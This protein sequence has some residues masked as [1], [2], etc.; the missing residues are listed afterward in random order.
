[1]RPTKVLDPV[2]LATLLLLS[3]LHWSELAQGQEA[4]T[5]P[6]APT[7]APA[8]VVPV[9]SI[10]PSAE[11]A[12]ISRDRLARAFAQRTRSMLQ[13]ELIFLGMLESGKTMLDMALELSPDNEHLWRLALDYSITMEDGSEDAAKLVNTALAKLGQLDPNDQI[14]RLRRVLASVERK[15]TAEARAAAYEKLLTPASIERLG[16]EVAARVAFDFAV[17]LRRVGDQEGFERELLRALDLDP[18]FPEATEVAAGYFRARAPDA[19]TEASVLRAALL[20]NPTRD[21]AALGLADLCLRSG[22]YRAAADILNVEAELL[23]TDFPDLDFDGILSDLCIACWGSDSVETALAVGRKRQESLNR[24]FR[25]QV[26]RQGSTLSV[27]DM[28]KLAY[29]MSMSLSST[30]AALV[31]SV[32]PDAAAGVLA[33]AAS[34]AETTLKAMEDGGADPEAI[35]R[36]ALEGAFIQLWLGGDIALAKRLIDRAVIFMPL[37]EAARARFDGWI[38]LRAGD[39]AKAK[40]MFSSVAESDVPAKLGLAVADEMLGDRKAAAREFLAIAKAQSATAIGLWSRDRLRTILGSPI[41]VVDI[42]TDVERAAALPKDFLDMMRTGKGQLLMRIQPRIADAAPWDPMIFDIEI[43]NRSAWPISITADGPLMD[44]ATVTAN[45]NIPGEPTVA[46]PFALVALNRQFAIAPGTSLFV[47][48]DISLTD[49][50][51]AMRDDALSGAFVS[52][53]PILN[54]RTTERGLEPGPL[55]IEAESALVHVRGEKVT[56]NWIDKVVADLRDTTRVPDPEKIA[57]LASVVTRD[58]K[59]K[60]LYPPEVRAALADM[61][62]LL[63]DAAKRLWPE[64]RAWLI[65]ASPKGG[66]RELSVRASDVAA[67]ASVDGAGDASSNAPGAEGEAERD[68]MRGFEQ[69]SAVPELEPLDLVLMSDEHPLVRTAWIAVRCKRPEDPILARS[70]ELGDARLVQFSKDFLSWMSDVV[71]ERRR[72][73]NLSQ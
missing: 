27:E 70:A 12:K 2:P 42:A 50:S 5:V 34:S 66:L 69:I 43:S 22:A 13:R 52:I 54:W 30:F 35:A 23:Q 1:M 29:P 32:A 53:H 49:A 39:A 31:Q 26:E 25:T 67:A 56:K 33:A 40:E 15:Q 36:T 3:Q 14:I 41:V 18:F 8:A 46:P 59:D 9:A 28:R 47:S 68:A 7:L 10:P 73:L 57:A 58:S 65:F 21:T 37:S 60:L 19:A 6:A 72:R 71:D 62:A 17:L 45:I 48:V 64:A 51:M 55:G 4:P 44:T 63:A 16:T 61:P 11:V 20:A 38:A 24:V